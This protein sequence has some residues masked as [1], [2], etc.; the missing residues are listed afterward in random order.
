MELAAPPKHI[1][2]KAHEGDPE[3]LKRLSK[4]RHGEHADVEDLWEYTQ[5]L[6]YTE[7]QGPLLAYL[8]PRCLE[9]WREDLRGKSGYG[10]FV[11]QFYP[12]LANR[13]VFD[14]HLTS[15]QTSAVSEFMRASI[16][17]EIDEQRGLAYQG[18]KVRPYR[19]INA[20]TTYGVLL[21]DMDRLWNALWNVST[22]G[23]AI[24]VVQYI[25][26][27]MYPDDGNP[28]FAPW[29]RD[30]GG[31]PPCLWEYEGH[32]YENSWLEPNVSFLKQSL[33]LGDAS[34]ALHQA[35]QRLVSQPEHSVAQK[36]QMDIPL[37]NETLSARCSELPRL[38]ETIQEPTTMLEWS[39]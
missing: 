28:I 27:L 35:V 38:L 3:H 31:G 15:S 8:L 21:P 2:Q 36:V 24:A 1:T 30:G 34:N 22:V 14:R 9:A 5:D 10:G 11:E 7:I 39:R 32:L 26:C 37:C 20:L 4:L 16:L 33:N 19:W 17:E 6:L 12:V 29:T 23:R 13:H 18:M 25:S